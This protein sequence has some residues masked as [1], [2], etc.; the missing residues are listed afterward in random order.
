MFP[1]GTEKGGGGGLKLGRTETLTVVRRTM[2]QS[3]LSHSI[4]NIEIYIVY[5]QSAKKY[6]DIIFCPYRAALIW[7]QTSQ[8]L[9]IQL[10]NKKLTTKTLRMAQAGDLFTDAFPMQKPWQPIGIQTLQTLSIQLSEK[11]LTT[12]ETLQITQACDF[13]TCSKLNGKG[14]HF[15]QSIFALLFFSKASDGFA[16]IGS[17]LIIFEVIWHNI[18]LV[19]VGG[20][21][22][23]FFFYKQSQLQELKYY[24]LA[25][26]TAAYW[27]FMN[28]LSELIFLFMEFLQ[29]LPVK[30]NLCP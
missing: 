12:T 4:E 24:W 9:Y 27:C 18:V 23:F 2:R 19:I 3:H 22:A 11:Q 1:N 5:R 17:R 6:R 21:I 8:N 26:Q 16:Q 28:G 25:M 29:N 30:S 15:R 20:I 7:I 13:F 10:S 14:T